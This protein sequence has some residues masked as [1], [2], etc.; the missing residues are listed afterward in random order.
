MKTLQRNRNTAILGAIIIISLGLLYYVLFVNKQPLPFFSGKSTQSDKK[1]GTLDK[2]LNA[3]VVTTNPEEA[4]K[5]ANEENLAVSDG[6]VTVVITVKDNSFI[7]TSQYGTEQIRYG[8]YIQ[9]QVKLTE[10]EKLAKNPKI[11]KIVGAMEATKQPPPGAPIII[12]PKPNP[13]PQTDK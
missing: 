13:S 12:S 7:F 9:A 11:E 2:N 5:K 1:I 6:K 10:L 8:K 4:L 3:V